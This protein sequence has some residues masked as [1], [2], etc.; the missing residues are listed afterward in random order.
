MKLLI[1]ALVASLALNAYL[2]FGR[3][4]DAS[5]DETTDAAPTTT[6]QRASKKIV[7]APSPSNPASY[8]TLDRKVLERRVLAAEA[9][10][11]EYLEPSE[12]FP[13]YT[14][15]VETEARVKP[16]LDLVFKKLPGTD[17]KYEVECRGRICKLDPKVEGDANAWMRP[18]QTTYPE[19][20]LFGSMAFGPNGT[21]LEVASEGEELAGKI[22]YDAHQSVHPCLH[23]SSD[24]GELT[25]QLV[26]DH[27]HVAFRMGG[28][29]RD[30][31]VGKCVAEAIR[32]SIAKFHVPPGVE[33]VD[34]EHTFTLPLDDDH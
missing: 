33:V 16:Y 19:R 7:F 3:A 29:L 8:G 13:K 22:G 24:T 18:L 12:K 2:V 15:S 26:M 5:S 30:H 17:P 6:S 9:E 32:Q 11:E 31:P 34:V 20:V 25:Y 21:F 10:V 1:A 23:E 28:S 27:G 14:R 4:S